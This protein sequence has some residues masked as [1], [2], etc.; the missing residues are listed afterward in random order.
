MHAQSAGSGRNA[1][2]I[3]YVLLAAGFAWGLLR[4]RRYNDAAHS[5]SRAAAAL[6]AQLQPSPP[7]AE[8]VIV[9]QNVWAHYFATPPAH[10]RGIT[11]VAAPVMSGLAMG[12]RLRALAAG[13]ARAPA[14]VVLVQELFLCRLGP[15]VLDG[16]FLLFR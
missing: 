16:N 4:R 1:A 14:D 5:S 15:L 12:A 9:S 10:F 13:L 11:G 2:T 6:G 8:L 7:P 3:V